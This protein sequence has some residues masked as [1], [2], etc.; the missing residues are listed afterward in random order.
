MVLYIYS[1]ATLL[2]STMFEHIIRLRN[3]LTELTRLAE[4]LET[5]GEQARLPAKITFNLNLAL[6]E[7]FTNIVSHGYSDT[8]EHE[9]EICLAIAEG[10]VRVELQDDGRPFN[11]LEAPPPTL[12]TELAERPVGGLGVYL[13]RQLM[14]EVHYRYEDGHNHL[15]LVKRY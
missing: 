15:L 12:T 2:C 7:L 8:A 10:V 6:D 5:F 11:P 1:E 3:A 9:I 4:I 13:A 14:D